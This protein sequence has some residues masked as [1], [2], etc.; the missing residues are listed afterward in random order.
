MDTSTLVG[1]L[2]VALL[3][4]A[5]FL[6]LIK[7]LP[8][9]S[10]GYIVLNVVGAGLACYASW[11]IGFLPFVVLEGTWSLVAAVALFR[12]FRADPA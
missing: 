6:N 9:D 5:F 3:L 10:M 12:R 11:L 7:R 4:I 2:G 8:Q 1:S